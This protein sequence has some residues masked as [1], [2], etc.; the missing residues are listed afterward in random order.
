MPGD[1][2]RSRSH[3]YVKRKYLKARSCAAP[4]GRPMPY[5]ESDAVD[6]YKIDL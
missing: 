5:A 1:L 6:D 3:T 4:L 2:P